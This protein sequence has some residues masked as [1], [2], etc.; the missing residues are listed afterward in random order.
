LVNPDRLRIANLTAH[1]LQRLNDILTA[2]AEP[3]IKGRVTLPPE[4]PS[5]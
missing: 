4:M 1:P 5:L 2:I 3:R